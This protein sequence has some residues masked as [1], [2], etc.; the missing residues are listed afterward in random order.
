ML[1]CS[2][3]FVG[4]PF[5]RDLVIHNLG[6]KPQQLTWTSQ[7]LDE[8]RKEYAKSM[9]ATGMEF[10][11][12]QGLVSNRCEVLFM[13]SI[14][15]VPLIWLGLGAAR[16]LADVVERME[17]HASSG[18]NARQSRKA[19]D[20]GCHALVATPLLDFSERTMTFHHVY[21]KGALVCILVIAWMW[22]PGV[23]HPPPHYAQHLQAAP[24]LQPAHWWP[25]LPGCVR[26]VS[27]AL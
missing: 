9:R 14:L 19:F 22:H 3:Q 23:N 11:G 21:T 5:Q 8:V 2:H 25:L 10:H 7:R 12:S 18:T 20:I 1:E 15:L 27:C 13:H 26:G 24:F 16:G 17:C 6:R 4:R